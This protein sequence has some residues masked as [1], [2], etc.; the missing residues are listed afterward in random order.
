MKA[1]LI[2]FPKL[3]KAAWDYRRDYADHHSSG[4][5]EQIK[6]QNFGSPVNVLGFSCDFLKKMIILIKV[7]TPG[8]LEVI[9]PHSQE[10]GISFRGVICLYHKFSEVLSALSSYVLGST[11]MFAVVI[12][13]S[14][15]PMICLGCMVIVPLHFASTHS[16]NSSLC[17]FAFR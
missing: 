16:G 14:S 1:F 4:E 10:I 13:P 5:S 8:H 6:W 3:I 15:Q 7:K 12:R 11:Q 17:A 2:F 9:C